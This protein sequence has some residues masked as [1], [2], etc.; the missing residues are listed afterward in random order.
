LK[1]FHHQ[2]ARRMANMMAYRDPGGDN[3]YPPLEEALKEAGCT[4]WNTM[5][6]SANCA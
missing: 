3:I 4:P 1:G 5:S 6:R 2:A